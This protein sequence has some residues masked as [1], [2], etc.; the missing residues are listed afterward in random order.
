MSDKTI[1]HF[2]FSRFFPKQD[3][4]YPYDVLDV[5]F[6][7]TQLALA[8]NNELKS[9]ENQTN[10]NFELVFLANPKYF[11]DPKYKFVFSTLQ[12]STTLPITFTTMANMPDLVKDAYE[13]YEFVIQSRMD[14]DDFIYKDAIADTQSKVNECDSVLIY[15]YNKGYVYVQGELYPEYFSK[16][17]TG[18]QSILQSLIWKSSFAK[19]IYRH[20]RFQSLGN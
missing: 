1:K 10:K 16:N 17:V 11:D 9:L 14:F 5:N 4:K 18:H 2:I 12:D 15:G 13:K 7:S 19:K 6:L 3:P 8:Q 20:I